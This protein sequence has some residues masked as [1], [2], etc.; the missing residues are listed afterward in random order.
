MAMKKQIRR[1]LR[2]KSA[3]IKSNIRLVVFIAKKYHGV[4]FQDLA[5]EGIIGLARACEKFN[6]EMG[7]RFSTYATW[8]IKASIQRCIQNGSRTIRLPVHINEQLTKKR[9]A[10]RELTFALGREPR[11]EEIAEL[12]EVD[13][14]R[15]C[16]LNRVSKHA[17][18]TETEIRSSKT[19]GSSASTGG[20]HGSAGNVLRL[21][22]MLHDPGQQPLDVVQRQMVKDDV[23]QVICTLK[24]REQELIRLRFGLDGGKPMTL[25]KLGKHFGVSMER[26]RQIE[27]VALDKLREPDRNRKLEQYTQDNDYL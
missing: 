25:A 18:S 9:R 11:T 12:M 8:W 2:A 10:Q 17:I 5:Q 27:C 13:A 16:F 22:D 7:Y 3:L 21:G 6:P 19:T 1:S 4:S 15:V 23:A 24:P 20:G 26:T 14:D